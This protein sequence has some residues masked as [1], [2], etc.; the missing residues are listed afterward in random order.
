MGGE[1]EFEAYLAEV[2]AFTREELI[3]GEERV[4]ELGRVPEDLVRRIREM[5][6]FAISIPEEY[7]GLGL[8]QEQQV[9]LTF[10]FTQASAVFRARFS[11]TIGLCSRRSSISPPRRRS[12]NT[13]PPWRRAAAPAPSR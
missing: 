4:E 12:G 7:G 13:C 1:L 9:R 2:E 3:P 11:T 10:A 5:R 6:L 8:S